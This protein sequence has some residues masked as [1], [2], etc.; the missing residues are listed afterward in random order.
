MRKKETLKIDV[1]LTGNFVR[2]RVCVYVYAR[3]RARA[4]IRLCAHQ[5]A[6]IGSEKNNNELFPTEMGF[7]KPLFMASNAGRCFPIRR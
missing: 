2:V 6:D 1:L 3:A 4:Y 7:I 5:K